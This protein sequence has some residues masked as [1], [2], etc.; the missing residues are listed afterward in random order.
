MYI[1]TAFLAVAG[2]WDHLYHRIP[3]LLTAVMAAFCLGSNLVCGGPAAVP[4]VLF[5]AFLTGLLF[6]PFFA[7][8]ALGAGDIKLLS[9]CSGFIPGGRVLYFVFLSFILASAF[10]L[11]KMMRR[12]DMRKRFRTLAMY[13]KD[14]SSSGRLR[15][16][17]CSR[18]SAV[19]NGV[20]LAGPMFISALLGIGGLY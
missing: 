8:G 14:V 7:I 1:M 10:G 2:I 16:Y 3:N 17:H 12:G 11:L 5:K 4:A 18:E 9:V 19:R 6:Y 20:A 15:R 13:I